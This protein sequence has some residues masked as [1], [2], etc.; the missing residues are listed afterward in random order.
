MPDS[1]AGAAETEESVCFLLTPEPFS[2]TVL[3]LQAYLA[4][5]DARAAEKGLRELAVPFF[6]HEFVRQAVMQ[7][8]QG[9]VSE[10]PVLA[11]LGRLSNCG[12]VSSNQLAKVTS[13]DT[14]W[15]PLALSRSL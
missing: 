8:L 9:A 3:L 6:H 13:D 5:G 14:I 10:A 2:D 4:H 15:F 7:A 12:L 1:D 11:L